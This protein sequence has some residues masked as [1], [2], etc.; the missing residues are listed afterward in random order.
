MCLQVCIDVY[1]HTHTYIHA[2]M[3]TYICRWYD[4]ITYLS[5]TS[6]RNLSASGMR[7]RPMKSCVP[8]RSWSYDAICMYVCM[9]VCMCACMSMYEYV[10]MYVCMYV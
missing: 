4:A 1:T 8:S 10:C 6:A 3:Q 5:A 9:Y 7:I 2:C